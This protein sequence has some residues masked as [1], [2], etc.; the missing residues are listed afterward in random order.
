MH[1]ILLLEISQNFPLLCLDFMLDY[2][3][4][5]YTSEL[6]IHIISSIN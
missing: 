6:H 2:A 3:N 4:S 1:E 5:N